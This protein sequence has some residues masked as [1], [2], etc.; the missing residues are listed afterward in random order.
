MEKPLE[1]GVQG[2]LLCQNLN[3]W[4]S[5]A[6]KLPLQCSGLRV[7][8]LKM[9][10]QTQAALTT[11]IFMIWCLPADDRKIELSATSAMVYNVSQSVPSV[12]SCVHFSLTRLTWNSSLVSFWILQMQ[13]FFLRNQ[14]PIVKISS[15]LYSL[16][17]S[18]SLLPVGKSK[19]MMKSGDCVIKHPGVFTTGLKLVVSVS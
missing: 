19:C 12:V 18:C 11:L 16:S 7:V 2:L 1:I 3:C 9:T 15:G 6:W 13:T 14:M 8:S 4:S 17:V 10:Y 5:P